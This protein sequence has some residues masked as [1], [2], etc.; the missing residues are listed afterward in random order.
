M[1]FGRMQIAGGWIYAQRV[2]VSCRRNT[3][4]CANRSGIEQQLRKEGRALTARCAARNTA[5]H[6]RAPA[7]LDPVDLQAGRA[8]ARPRSDGTDWAC[9]PVEKV[10]GSPQRF[11]AVLG[12]FM[13]FTPCHGRYAR[14]SS[15]R[16]LIN[17]LVLEFYSS[18]NETYP[19]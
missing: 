14:P 7:F 13:I 12:N 10:R 16:I 4:G 15:R 17:A 3:F 6:P 1:E 9:S 19:E 2:V 11:D 5:E 18:K 8:P